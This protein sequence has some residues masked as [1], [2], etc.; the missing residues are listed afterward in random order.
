MTKVENIFNWCIER[1][2]GCLANRQIQPVPNLIQEDPYA[3]W[4]F[5]KLSRAVK[6]ALRYYLVADPSTRL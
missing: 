4:C 5:D 2:L 1:L 3:W 6:G